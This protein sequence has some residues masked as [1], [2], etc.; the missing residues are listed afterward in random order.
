[1]WQVHLPLFSEVSKEKN[2]KQ[3]L[4]QNDDKQGYSSIP[5]EEIPKKWEFFFPVNKIFNFRKANLV[6]FKHKKGNAIHL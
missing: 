2:E 3:P 5:S 6:L 1:M 4:T